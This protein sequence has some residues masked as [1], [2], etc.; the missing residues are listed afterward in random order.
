M[1]RGG[2]TVDELQGNL[3]LGE[4]RDGLTLISRVGVKKSECK[5]AKCGA[6][7]ACREAA[8]PGLNIVTQAQD[9]LTLTNIYIQLHE[10]THTQEKPFHCEHCNKK[11]ALKAHLTRHL[12]IHSGERPYSCLHCDK[13]FN[14]SSSRNKHMEQCIENLT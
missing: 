6:P 7:P 4:S 1:E 3:T 14:H 8:S 11:F 9:T 12:R 5:P 2:W 10:R 13:T